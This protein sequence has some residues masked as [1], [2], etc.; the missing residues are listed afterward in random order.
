MNLEQALRKTK[1]TEKFR[2][3]VSKDVNDQKKE[4]QKA[5]NEEEVMRDAYKILADI[6]PENRDKRIKRIKAGK[7]T[8]VGPK[9]KFT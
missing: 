9:I 7:R 4:A 1:K 2:Q 8:R 6:K 3:E 5:F